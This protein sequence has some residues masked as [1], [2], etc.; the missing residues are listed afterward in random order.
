M[1][2]LLISMPFGAVDRPALGISLLKAGLEGQGVQ[3]DVRYLFAELV[4]RIGLSDYQWL[5]DDVPYTSFA[6]DWCFTLPL[7]GQDIDT[8][9]AYVNSILADTWQLSREDIERIVNI[10][11]QTPA[12]LAACLEKV[13]WQDYDV[14]GFTSTFTQNM[15]SLAMARLVKQSYP[16]IITVFGGANWED[17]MGLALHQ[18]FDFVDYACSGEADLSF[19]KLIKSLAEGNHQPSELRGIVYRDGAGAS[20]QSK[21]A[22]PVMDMDSLP[23][24]DY[25]DY[26][27]LLRTSPNLMGVTPSML[28]ETSRGCWWG[29]K[30]HCTF[31]GLN[32]NGMKYRV[33]KAS[34]ALDEVIELTQRWGVSF[35]FM[36][37][38]ILDMGYLK[39]F[40]KQVIDSKYTFRFFYETKANLSREQ[41]EILA[42]A[43]VLNI[44]PGIESLSD[45][46]LKLM[47]KGTSA[48][49]NIQLLKW[50]KEYKISVDWNILYGFPGE[51]DKDYA[52]SKALLLK[53]PHLQEPSGSGPIRLDRFSPFFQTPEKFGLRNVRAMEVFRYL[54]PF[55]AQQVDRIACYFDFDYVTKPA[56]AKAIQG[57]MGVV[58]RMSKQRLSGELMAIDYGNYLII[59]DSRSNYSLSNYE[60]RDYDRI[61]YLLCDEM[62]SARK[63]QRS[64]KSLFPN[65]SFC[66]DDLIR[67]LDTL[68]NLGLM[69]KQSDRYLA[70][71]TYDAYPADWKQTVNN[72]SLFV[73]EKASIEPL[74]EI[75]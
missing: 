16:Q 58:D 3:C 28:M 51:T 69:A 17:E 56:S 31:C 42:K 24:P 45:H 8:E 62:I 13:N 26:F 68:E 73:P 61:L 70:L 71:A 5:T 18:C 54:Y 37:D 44:Q 52:D 14:V 9:R 30:H 41:V 23:V 72:L 10:R 36:V 40:L 75:I 22:L 29:A 7:Y 60:L 65:H 50:C 25:A 2:V 48:L 67:Q 64:L 63:V 11:E 59:E 35:V 34:R 53:I 21:P 33:K 32:G 1:R 12:Y 39:S 57:V 6:G 43:G 49:Q 20:T 55:P 38:N 27:R 15:A 19:P 74:G 46:V 66:Y 47:R 4:D